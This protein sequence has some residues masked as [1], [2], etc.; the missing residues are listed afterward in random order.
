MEGQAGLLIIQLEEK[1]GP[2]G[3][4]LRKR[5]TEANAD[6]LREWGIRLVKADRLDQVFR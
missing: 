3:E 6:A 2:L 4:A 5:V 1:F